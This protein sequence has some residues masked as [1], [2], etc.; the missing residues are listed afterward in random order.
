MKYSQS[1]FKL[2]LIFY[3]ML[4]ASCNK[5]INENIFLKMWDGPYDG[6]PHFDKMNIDEIKPAVEKALELSLKEINEIANQKDTANF[7]NTIGK[8]K[9]V[10]SLIE[11]I[12]FTVFT[13]IIYLVLNFKK[14]N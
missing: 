11:C 2:F 13:V 10:R 14:S 12:L 7:E 6:I 9:E 5:T 1:F 4:T 3:I 8:W